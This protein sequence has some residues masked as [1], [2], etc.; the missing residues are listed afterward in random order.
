MRQPPSNARHS[1]RTH[2]LRTFCCLPIRSV[3]A[4]RTGTIFDA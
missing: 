3:A 4:G 2:E 1:A